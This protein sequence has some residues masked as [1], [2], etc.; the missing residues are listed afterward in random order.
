MITEF[1]CRL[2]GEIGI[3]MQSVTRKATA[4]D[5]PSRP[6]RLRGSKPDDPAYLTV[7]W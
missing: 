5:P 1:F 2:P 3:C 7:P 6:L 4:Q